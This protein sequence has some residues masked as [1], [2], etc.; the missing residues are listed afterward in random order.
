M[1]SH[2]R[3]SLDNPETQDGEAGEA[4]ESADEFY[5][6]SQHRH[7]TP[8]TETDDGVT[9][10]EEDNGNPSRSPLGYLLTRARS[11]ASQMRRIRTLIRLVGPF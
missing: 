3:K 8:D 9:D 11:Y 10:D 6:Y 4:N 5:G 7:G 2:S 1:A